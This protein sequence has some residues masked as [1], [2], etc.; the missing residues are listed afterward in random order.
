MKIIGYLALCLLL[1]KHVSALSKNV[2]YI[3]SQGPRVASNSIK[4][5]MPYV[6]Y[7]INRRGSESQISPKSVN[8]NIKLLM[9]S[10]LEGSHFNTRGPVN[11]VQ[12]SL[13]MLKT[14]ENPQLQEILKIEAVTED[15][16]RSLFNKFDSVTPDGKITI[17]ELG[18]AMVII[19]QDYDMPY[20]S[21][22]D[23]EDTMRDSD[24]DSTGYL[25]YDQFKSW[26]VGYLTKAAYE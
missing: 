6:S 7:K 3:N 5:Y 17:D 1:L 24:T 8:G 10:Q 25:D 12:N 9:K 16:V 23:M 26:A 20:P 4:A 14:R 13:V 15:T 11:T 18:N 21:Q 19:A 22:R 2:G